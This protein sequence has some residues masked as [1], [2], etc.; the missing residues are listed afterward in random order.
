M[1]P[2]TTVMIKKIEMSLEENLIVFI[3]KV[4]D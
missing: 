4:L 3:F 2:E 1:Q